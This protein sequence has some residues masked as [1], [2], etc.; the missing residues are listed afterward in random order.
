MLD[1]NNSINTSNISDSRVWNLRIFKS[2]KTINERYIWGDKRII[3]RIK[4]MKK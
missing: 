1:G 3:R 4:W 2:K